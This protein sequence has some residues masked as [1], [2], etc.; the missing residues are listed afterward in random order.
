MSTLPINALSKRRRRIVRRRWLIGGV[1]ATAVLAVTVTAL[2][3]YHRPLSV[4]KLGDITVPSWITQDF[5][6]FGPPSRSGLPLSAFH[7]VVVHYVGNPGTTAKQ[8]RN[9][10]D[11][12][13]SEVSSHFVVGLEGEV[14]QC[15]PLSERS[16]ASNHRN[17]DTISIEVC[18]PDDTGEF[19][20]ATY[21][22]VVTLVAWLLDTGKLERNHVIRHYDVTGK[23]CPRYFV[24][25]PKAWNTFRKDV[26]AKVLPE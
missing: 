7:D 17:H 15:L 11:N 1:A 10:F 13:L 9:W 5:I 21:D 20:K 24:R 18:H 2:A 26:A 6:R 8:N 19:T 3:L 12:P 22:A 25:H 14:I 23:E 4:K 16:A